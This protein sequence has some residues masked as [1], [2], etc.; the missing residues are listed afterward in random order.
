[1]AIFYL[2][3]L[4]SQSQDSR[5]E[6]KVKR[7][8]HD[9]NIRP[10]LT[11]PEKHKYDQISKLRSANSITQSVP[12]ANSIHCYKPRVADRV[13]KRLGYQK[14]LVYF[15]WLKWNK[16]PPLQE[17]PLAQTGI[18]PRPSG[19]QPMTLHSIFTVCSEAMC[20]SKKYVNGPAGHLYWLV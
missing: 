3:K 18:A 1:M 14:C 6:I 4:A 12:F 5:V 11:R 2:E 7:P 9:S 19:L 20:K 16:I 17:L 8:G 10:N 15:L 13:Y